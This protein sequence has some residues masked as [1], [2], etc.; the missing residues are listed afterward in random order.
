[1]TPI[2]ILLTAGALTAAFAVSGCGFRPI[3]ATT[4]ADGVPLTQRISI[5]EVNGS[6]TVTPLLADALES[7]MVLRE[8]ES[9]EYE[10]YVATTERAQRLAVQ[11]DAS[12][13]RYNYRLNGRYTLVN[14]ETGRRTNGRARAVTSFNIVN[15]QY[16]TLYA[17]RNAQEKAAR[18]LADEIERDLLI[19]LSSE[20][21]ELEDELDSE[22]D[23]LGDTDEDFLPEIRRRYEG[24]N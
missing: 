22:E 10:L 4:E 1:M 3:Y 11:I 5:R 7:R 23:F 19:R 9:P 15:S 12:V 20:N 14:I 21:T 24:S 18:L 16:S 6:D 17:E 8:G 13:T 2:K